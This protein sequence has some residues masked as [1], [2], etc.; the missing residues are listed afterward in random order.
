MATREW[1]GNAAAVKQVNTWLFAGTWEATDV[2]NITINSKTLSVV[3]GS[4]VTATVAA[5]VQAALAAST[6]AEFSEIT[7]TI[8]TATITGTGVTAGKPFSCTFA[9]TETGGGAADAQTI[10]GAASSTGTAVTAATGPNHADNTANWTSSTLPITGDDVVIRRPISILYGLTAF[11]AVT[12]ATLKI[13]SQ[14]W[15]GGARIG[16][17]EI[18]GSGSTAY[19]EYRN[20]FLQWSGATLCEIGLGESTGGSSLINLDFGTG[21]TAITV[22]RTPQSADQAR[23]TVCLIVN[24]GTVSNGNLEVLSGSVGVGFYNESC[25]VV[26]KIGYRDNQAS[27]ARVYFGPNVT[28]GATFDQSGGIVEINSATTLITKTGGTL[29]ING[30]GAHPAVNNFEGLIA[31]NSTGTLAGSAV[32]VIGGKGE[33]T[34]T[35]DMS[36]KTV[37]NV[38]QLSPG[39][40]LDDSHG[41]V[42]SGGNPNL[43]WR[44]LNCRMSDVTIRTPVNRTY[45]IS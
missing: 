28:F 7:W 12:P 21:T 29:T 35:Q 16:L 44:L 42:Q 6:Y 32:T 10:N 38:F 15:A 43:S 14:F 41:R 24:P 31:Y 30:T 19:P 36:A 3:A 33:F 18:N 23:P 11:A 13:Y 37:T 2:I 45:T 40:I 4:T 17:P 34:F 1:L 9:T 27:D 25:K 8:D 26:P 39:A 22:H 20:K 5:T